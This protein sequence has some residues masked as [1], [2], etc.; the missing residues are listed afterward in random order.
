M[1][2]VY[3]NDK[4]T[5]VDPNFNGDHCLRAILQELKGIKEYL[6][7]QEI[8]INKTVVQEN[9]CSCVSRGVECSS[10][11][12]INDVNY[13]KVPI[14]HVCSCGCGQIMQDNPDDLPF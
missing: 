13:S 7:P 3:Y 12:I 9:K 4:N 10:V 6:R 1:K 5:T 11:N 2:N 14:P 8:V